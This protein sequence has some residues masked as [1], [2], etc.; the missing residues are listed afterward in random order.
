MNISKI[1]IT[2]WIVAKLANRA[3][4]ITGADSLTHLTEIL[5]KQM[6]RTK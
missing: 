1:L 3:S 4:F 5:K 2:S 6:K